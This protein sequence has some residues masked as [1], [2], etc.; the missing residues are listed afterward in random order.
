MNKKEY[1]NSLLTEK[2]W[3]L[4]QEIKNKY[5]FILI[6]GWA[7][8]LLA[9][10]QKSKDIDIVIDIKQLEKLKKENLIKNDRLKKYEIK[11]EEIDIDIYVEYYSELTLPVQDIKNYAIKIQGYNVICPEALLILKQGA[12]KDREYS[13]KGEKDKIDIISIIFFTEIDLNKYNQI[14]EKYNLGLYKKDLKK[15]LSGFKDYNVLGITP[16]ELKLKKEQII[17]KIN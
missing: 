11:I 6:G 9:K 7:A 17:K 4:L 12:Y 13:V 1:W 16:R 8:Y 5:E 15:L 3:K 14:L 10:Q 2:S